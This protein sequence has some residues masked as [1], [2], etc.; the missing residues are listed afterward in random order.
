MHGRIVGDRKSKSGIFALVC[1]MTRGILLNP[2]M[3]FCIY[4]IVIIRLFIAVAHVKLFCD[5]VCNVLAYG[6]H[7]P[8]IFPSSLEFKWSRKNGEEQ[9]LNHHSCEGINKRNLTCEG[10]AMQFL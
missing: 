5:D 2:D 8:Q 3:N 9:W 10:S 4:E 7:I 6:E 1:H